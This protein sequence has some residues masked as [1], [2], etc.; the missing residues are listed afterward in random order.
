M[1]I[2]EVLTL[3]YDYLSPYNPDGPYIRIG[4]FDLNYNDPDDNPCEDC[5]DYHSPHCVMEREHNDGNYCCSDCN[6]YRE[7]Y[8]FCSTWMGVLET[9]GTPISCLPGN[10]LCGFGKTMLSAWTRSSLR[11]EFDTGLR[12]WPSRPF[13]R[14]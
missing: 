6:E 8:C 12:T 5:E 4:K 9:F 10:A 1:R 14:I 3:L 13:S 2:A 7:D 11:P